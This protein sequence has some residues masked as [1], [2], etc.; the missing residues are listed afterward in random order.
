MICSTGSVLFTTARVT[1]IK[2]SIRMIRS[3]GSVCTLLGTG[4]LFTKESGLREFST[5][6]A[7]SGPKMAPSTREVGSKG[8]SMG[9]VSIGGQTE[10]SIRALLRGQSLME[11]E[12]ISRRR[13]ISIQE[14]FIMV[15]CTDRELSF[16]VTD[17]H[18]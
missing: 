17:E 13:G 11:K 16:G 5:A 7:Q 8:R 10:G 14:T 3:R 9:K 12:H 2:G 6:R 18:T 1:C 4:T 15:R